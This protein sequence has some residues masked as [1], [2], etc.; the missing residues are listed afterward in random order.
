MEKIKIKTETIKL[1]QFLKWAEITNSGGEAKA[2]ITEGLVKLN[3][4]VE[5]RRGKV[6]NSGDIIEFQGKKY[7]VNRE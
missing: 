4:E 1:D 7:Q 2:L 5:I 6:L 3:G